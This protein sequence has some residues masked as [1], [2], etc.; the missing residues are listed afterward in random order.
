MLFFKRQPD[1]G[2][3]LLRLFVSV[4]LLYGVL[5][6]IMSWNRML[7]FRD[8]LQLFH[9]PM[10]LV[11]AMVSVYAQAIAAVLIGVGWKIRW[12]AVLMIVNFTIA[13]VVVHRD[14]SF[15]QMTPPLALL[16]SSVL[17]LFTGAGRFSADR[18]P[19]N[20]LTGPGSE[21]YKSA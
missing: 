16:F 6:N 13:V 18:E 3:L 5:D 17:F 1:V 10:P 11:S 21:S 20:M 9:F 15:E 4:R 2:V 7:E 14:Q 19:L 8:F 12:A